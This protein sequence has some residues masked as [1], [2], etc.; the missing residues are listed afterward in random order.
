[1]P[2]SFLD[3]QQTG[4]E[5]IHLLCILSHIANHEPQRRWSVWRPRC[6]VRQA[7]VWSA[8]LS[9]LSSCI[10]PPGHSPGSLAEGPGSHLEAGEF[11][12]PHGRSKKRVRGGLLERIPLG[13]CG[14]APSGR[15]L[16]RLTKGLSHPW[17]PASGCASHLPWRTV[18][19][20][21]NH[22]IAIWSSVMSLRRQTQS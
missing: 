6:V 21:P 3:L 18:P 17:E 7:E 10:L 5:K 19:T 13:L 15:K 16:R 11:Q 4:S 2:P 8:S 14:T 9:E 12:S 1:M 22:S 20:G